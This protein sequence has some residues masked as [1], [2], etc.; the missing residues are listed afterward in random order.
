MTNKW[1]IK[2]KNTYYLKTPDKESICGDDPELNSA[3]DHLLFQ[4]TSIEA[5]FRELAHVL[6]DFT[7]YENSSI[8]NTILKNGLIAYKDILHTDNDSLRP[9]DRIMKFLSAVISTAMK[10]CTFTVIDNNTGETW[11]ISNKS[12]LTLWRFNRTDLSIED[13]SL[14]EDE[15]AQVIYSKAIPRNIKM[16]MRRHQHENTILVG[17]MGCHN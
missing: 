5:L 6:T 8:V 16:A 12:P 17:D 13:N 1:S 15:I 14:K 10:L 3:Y 2:V 11:N 9:H 7:Y 4:W